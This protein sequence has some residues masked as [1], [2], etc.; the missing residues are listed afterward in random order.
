VAFVSLVLSATVSVEA[1]G[2]QFASTAVRWR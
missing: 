2:F 1:T